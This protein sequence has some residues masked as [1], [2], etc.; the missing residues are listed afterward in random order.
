M[1]FKILIKIDKID[2]IFSKS[3]TSDLWKKFDST[4]SENTNVELRLIHRNGRVSQYALPDNNEETQGDEDKI[5]IEIFLEFD[6][7]NKTKQKYVVI[8]K[9]EPMSP[10]STTKCLAM[11]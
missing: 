10:L 3:E 1:C 9:E 11:I 4:Q 6:K 8:E 5:G 2:P 7:L